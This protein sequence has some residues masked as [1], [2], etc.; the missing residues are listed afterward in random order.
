MDKMRLPIFFLSYF[1]FVFAVLVI[2]FRASHMQASSLP[3]SSVH[4]LCLWLKRCVCVCACMCVTLNR[5]LN[6]ESVQVKTSWLRF[7]RD[8]PF[9]FEKS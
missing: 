8:G 7:S 5:M 9:S 3:L 1:Y 6:L 2:E 4:S